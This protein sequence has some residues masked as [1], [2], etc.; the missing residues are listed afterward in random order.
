MSS[1]ECNSNNDSYARIDLCELKPVGRGVKEMSVIVKLFDKPISNASFGLEFRRRGYFTQPIYKYVVDACLFLRNKKRNPLANAFYDFLQLAN[2]SNMNHT[3]PYNHDL[4][5]DRFRVDKNLKFNL[6]IEK[7]DYTVEVFLHTY[8]VLRG[9][10][11]ANLEI[12]N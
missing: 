5:V 8:N 2:K 6:P 11:N 3:C 4:I 1:I 10:F 12:R 7:G 9:T